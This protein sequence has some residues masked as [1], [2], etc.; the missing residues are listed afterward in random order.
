MLDGTALQKDIYDL[1]ANP[2]KYKINEEDTKV[3]AENLAKMITERLNDRKP[4]DYISL[5]SYSTPD[6][7]LWYK[8]NKPE[9][10]GEIQP[11]VRL[12]FLYG[13]IIEMLMIYL[14]KL[15]GHEVKGEQSKVDYMGIPGTRDCIVDGQVVDV[16]SANSRGMYKFKGHNLETDDPFGYLSQLTLYGAASQD[17]PDVKDKKNVSFI[18][19]DKEL[20]HVVVDT[21]P[22]K[23]VPTEH[24]VKKKVMMLAGGLPDRC[25]PD[26]EEGR[27]GNRKLGVECSYCDYKHACWPG[28]RT[29][30][31]SKGPM[32][33]TH[34]AEEPNVP[35]VK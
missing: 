4:R 33:L 35:E 17:D 27:K 28:L 3:F 6:R 16:K 1:L 21:Y 14:I 24:E 25:Y 12:K 29:F 13:D 32:Y 19:V 26:Q 15:S 20:G 23:D 22:I 11:N 9:L 2:H 8:V 5:S 34:V 18:A 10:A 30:L 7:K 31:Y